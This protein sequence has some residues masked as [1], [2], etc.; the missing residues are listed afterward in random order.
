MDA[1]QRQSIPDAPIRLPPK[2]GRAAGSLNR[3]RTNREFTCWSLV[4]SPSSAAAFA[5]GWTLSGE[6]L[7][8]RM[9]GGGYAGNG[10]GEDGGTAVL[11]EV[12]SLKQWKSDV[13]P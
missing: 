7:I 9:A 8:P 11:V 4:N 1:A 3:Q 13:H 10:F 5:V 12:K 2:A 6:A